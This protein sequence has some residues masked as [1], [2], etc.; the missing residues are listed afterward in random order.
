MSALERRIGAALFERDNRTVALTH[1]GALFLDYARDALTQWDVI[2]HA[3]MEEAEA[4]LE[5]L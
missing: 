1:E 3:L 2:R 4:A 5:T